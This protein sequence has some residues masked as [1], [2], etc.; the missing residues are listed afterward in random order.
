MFDGRLG[1]PHSEYVAPASMY[2][3]GASVDRKAVVECRINP[4]TGKEIRGDTTNLQTSSLP[5]CSSF[6][7]FVKIIPSLFGELNG[8]ICALLAYVELRVRFATSL[9]CGKRARL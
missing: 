8:G 9:V 6:M 1:S 4:P 7:V 5:C 3:R 2:P